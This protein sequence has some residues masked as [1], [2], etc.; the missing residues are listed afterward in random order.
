MQEEIYTGAIPYEHKPEQDFIIATSGEPF[1]WEKGYDINFPLRAKN[2]YQSY[3]CGGF[4]CSYAMQVKE[5]KDVQSPK[6][7]YANT[8]AR[9]N[10]GTSY[11]AL[12]NWLV[13]KGSCDESLCV[14]FLP[15]GTTNER[16]IT[17]TSDITEWAY[18]DAVTNKIERYAKTVNMTID[19]VAKALRDN[20]GLFLGVWGQD[21]GTWRTDNPLPPKSKVWA[22]WLFGT[23][24]GMYKGKK[25]IRIIN[26]WGNLTGDNGYQ[27][28]TEDYFPN[29]IFLAW[30][31]TGNYEIPKHEFTKTIKF[32][33]KSDEV[34]FLQMK[35]ETLGFL[36]MPKGVA[37]GYYGALTA[38]GVF[39]FQIKNNVASLQEIQKLGGKLVGPAT[40]KALN[41]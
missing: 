18:K 36:T 14:S 9:P 5:G 12:G 2:Q 35:L 38:K 6:F 15:D 40:R 28:L 37:Y 41:K 30:T 27:W 10:G 20:R 17:N 23:A 1:D 4:M 33:E 26:S 34:K 7:I 32:G 8:W 25:A 29:G 21:N 16:F 3:A 19:E 13:N 22:H 39:D 24:A 31:I 11:E